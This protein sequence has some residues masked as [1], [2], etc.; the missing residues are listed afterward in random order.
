[1]RGLSFRHGASEALDPI[2]VKEDAPNRC[3]RSLAGAISE[4]HRRWLGAPT[5]YHSRCG[6]NQKV[7]PPIKAVLQHPCQLCCAALRLRDAGLRGL[8]PESVEGA[9]DEAKELGEHVELAPPAP[10]PKLLHLVVVAVE[11][12][13]HVLQE[14]SC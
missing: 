7:D 14:N 9:R 12:R 1:M 10:P 8:A 11:R 13:R 4:Q 6:F 2:A 3:A 5:G